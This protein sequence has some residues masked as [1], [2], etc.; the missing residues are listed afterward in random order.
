[1]T[2]YS[3]ATQENGILFFVETSEGI[4]ISQCANCGKFK[5]IFL[6]PKNQEFDIYKNMQDFSTTEINII[7]SALKRNRVSHGLCYE[8]AVEL[9]GDIFSN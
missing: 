3:L 4:V 9:Y 5:T 8:C 7:E 6:D 1:M 2:W